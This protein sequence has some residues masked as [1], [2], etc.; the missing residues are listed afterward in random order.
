MFFSLFLQL[1]SE[2]SAVTQRYLCD[3]LF[4][5]ISNCMYRFICGEQFFKIWYQFI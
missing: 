3:Q 4:A 5:C 1:S 2:N